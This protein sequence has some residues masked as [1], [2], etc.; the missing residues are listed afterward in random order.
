[1]INPLRSGEGVSVWWVKEAPA[2]FRL[3]YSGRWGGASEP[4]FH[5]LNLGFKGGDEP[6]RVLENRKRVAEA[7]KMPLERWTLL[8][9]V[10]SDA[11]VMV[12]EDVVGAGSR[13]YASGVDD[14][15]AMVTAVRGAA[16]CVLAADCLPL[17]V[18]GG[19]PPV[20][21]LAHAGRRGL[22]AGLPGKVVRFLAENFP[23]DPADLI[24]WLGPC[25]GRCCYE[26]SEDIAEDF[27]RRFDPEGI[28]AGDPHSVV[29][30]KGGRARLDLRLA[31]RR[32]LSSA[33]VPPERILGSSECTCCEPRFF[34]HR[35]E[36]IT[37]RQAAFIWIE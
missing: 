2:P 36:G 3:A 8:R 30:L 7:L 31:A 22:L 28:E 25:I 10:H 33:G 13:D 21:A 17:A 4:P 23:V 6:A 37:G 12:G 34:S 9:Q 14:A 5:Q 16:L 35:R 32:D 20:A 27:K 24:A 19:D 26:V 1:M 29:S 15:D 11:V 18:M